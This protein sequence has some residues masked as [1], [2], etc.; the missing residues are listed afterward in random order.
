MIKLKKLV[1]ILLFNTIAFTAI[2][3]KRKTNFLEITGTALLDDKPTDNYAISVYLD[4]TKIDSMYTKKVKSIFFLVKYNELYTFLFQKKNCQDKIVIVNTSIPEGLD[5]MK[6]DIFEFEV[7][8]T[9]SLV[10]KS[11]DLEDYP[12]AVLRINKEEELLEA[13]EVY[14]KFTHNE[15]E[16][17]SKNTSNVILEK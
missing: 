16:V 17:I 12:V 5:K 7:E 3:Q 9:Q 14:N 10:K 15:D 8:M 11:E 2:S 1:L 6:D 4:G 13:S